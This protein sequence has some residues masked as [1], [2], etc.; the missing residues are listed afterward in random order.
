METSKVS[1]NTTGLGSELKKE[2]LGGS[3]GM[4]FIMEKL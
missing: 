2:L 3:R 4:E 1:C